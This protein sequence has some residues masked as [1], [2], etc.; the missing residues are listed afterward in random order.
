MGPWGVG[1]LAPSARSVLDE[2]TQGF[3]SQVASKEA[4]GG[5]RLRACLLECVCARERE[6][7][8]CARV[9]V[10]GTLTA[11]YFSPMWVAG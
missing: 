9:C 7:A 6:R 11:F 8:R 1:G 3:R 5:G 10:N 4:V 2:T